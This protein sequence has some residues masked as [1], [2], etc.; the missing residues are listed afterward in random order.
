[1]FDL[2]ITNG[3]LVDGTGSPAC[4]RDIGITGDTITAIGDLRAA[5]SRATLD[6][7]ARSSTVTP[8]FIDA[9]SHSDTYLLIEPTSPSKTRQGVTTEVVGN[10]GASAAPLVGAAH[11][12]SDWDDKEYPGTW[13]S[14]EE[15][16]EL[17][18]EAQPTPNVVFLIGHNTLRAG[19]MGYENRPATRDELRQMVYNLEQGFSQGAHG[20]SVGLVYPPGMF[21]PRAELI[22][23][24]RTVAAHEGIFAGHMRNERDAL[25]EAVAEMLD[26]GKTAGVRVQVSHL[27]AAGRKNWPL[28]D[29]ALRLI[30]QAR[31]EGTDIAADRY[32]YTCSCTELDVIFPEWAGEGGREETVRRLGDVSQRARLREDLLNSRSDDYWETVTIGSTSHPENLGFRGMPLPDVARQ[33]DMTPV[34]A[35]LHL[36]ETDQLKTTAFFFGM[37]GDNMKKVLGESYIMIGS[38][39]SLRSPSGPLGHDHPHPRAYGSFP[40]F[41]KMAIEGRTVSLAEAIRKVTSL[42]AARFGL[43]DRGVIAEGRKADI[44]V[45]DREKISD[46]ATYAKPHQPAAG[47]DHVIIN[48]IQAITKGCPTTN[49]PGRV[50]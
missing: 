8:G 36:T 45:F 20:L 43:K 35:V 15:Y 46:K 21:T 30:R 19:V 1:M 50:L 10:C 23:L 31:K 12:P 11:M 42:P 47:I 38:D 3:Q 13:H 17:L 40:R 29:E 48:G 6:L 44:V 4:R 18:Q 5:A 32:P 22:E 37:S 39:A 26:I 7:D 28:I 14:V 9:H 41:I 25:P 16:R 2:T 34:D 49:R 33:L 24:A 27:K